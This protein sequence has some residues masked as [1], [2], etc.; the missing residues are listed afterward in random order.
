MFGAFLIVISLAIAKAPTL[1]EHL[2][3]S[4][5]G[6]IEKAAM[7][8]A[9]SQATNSSSAGEH[10]PSLNNGEEPT[11]NAL[12]FKAVVLGFTAACISGKFLTILFI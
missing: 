2:T 12:P 4:G 11:V 1:L 9:A 3:S 8:A 6:Q 10:L 7:A 5:E